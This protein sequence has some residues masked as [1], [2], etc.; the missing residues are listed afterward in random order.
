MKNQTI[1]TETNGGR[2]H[3]MECQRERPGRDI[4]VKGTRWVSR[5]SRDPKPAPN[6]QTKQWLSIQ[7]QLITEQC[8]IKL[9]LNVMYNAE[10]A[11]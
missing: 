6:S 2:V 11:L 3:M 4:N 10:V 5:W 9:L 8:Y 7:P 1:E